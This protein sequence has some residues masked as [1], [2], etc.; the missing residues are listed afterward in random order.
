VI[1]IAALRPL[2]V[3]QARVLPE[4]V[5][6]DE[7][8]L[9]KAVVGGRNVRDVLARP[10]LAA[11]VKDD[12]RRDARPARRERKLAPLEREPLDLEGQVG[13]ALPERYRSPS[14]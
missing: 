6:A 2:L 12:R 9:R 13:D 4:R 8:G 14:Q 1:R 5:A 11:A 3:E 10:A 7:V